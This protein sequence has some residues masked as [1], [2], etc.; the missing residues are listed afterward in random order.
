MAAVADTFD[1]LTSDR[2]YRRA[3]SYREAVARVRVEAGPHLD[4]T[5][6][7]ALMRTLAA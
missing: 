5:V 6:V 2:P 1:V 7:D 4:P 3:F